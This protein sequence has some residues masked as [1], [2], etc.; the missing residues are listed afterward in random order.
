M[1][2][3]GIGL[4]AQHGPAAGT[5]L[6]PPEN[7]FTSGQADFSDAA[8][9]DLRSN[10]T[11]AQNDLR[12]I[13]GNA[14][15]NEVRMALD[16]PITIGNP[17][18]FRWDMAAAASAGNLRA[19][20][21]GDGVLSG[22]NHDATD[23]RS[24]FQWWP[25]PDIVAAYPRF[26]L[27]P[28]DDLFDAPVTGV[29]GYDLAPVDP[30]STACDVVLCLGD[31]N[32]SN[33]ASDFV[34]HSNLTTDFDPRV[35]YMP[36]LR[37]TASYDTTMSTRHVP[38]PCHEPVVGSAGGRRMSPLMAFGVQFAEYSAAQGRPLLLLSLG[39]AGSGLNGTED[40]RN[41]S[42]VAT[43]GARMYDEMLAMVAAMNALGPAHRVVGAIISLGANDT[44]GA[45]Y[46]ATWV[47]QAQQFVSDL[48]S[49]P[50]IGN[51]GLP[52]CWITVGDHYEPVPGEDRGARMI[53]AI[54]S[55]DQDSGSANAVAGVKA[56]RPPSGNQIDPGDA[57]NPHFNA[58]G[59]Q[60]N[61]TVMADTLR[62]LL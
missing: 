22:F 45:D 2:G 9:I 15:T 16:A 13:A 42:A 56:I 26:E 29:D 41:T 46:D 28:N 3:V 40:W 44:T 30:A 1:I 59:M 49:E 57:A 19:R 51:A 33:A 48:R 25:G 10:W 43:T 21:G 50:G 14:N 55:L 39:D 53:A 31:S 17:H 35:W 27:K 36:C 20:L 62:L 6:S 5:A 24:E 12:Q 23:Q 61:G 4:A 47:P 18:F 52:V 60:A 32:M 58:A 7:L 37:Q 38:Q 34:S 8:H 54:E 11:V